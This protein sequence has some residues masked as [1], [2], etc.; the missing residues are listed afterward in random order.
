[1]VDLQRQIEYWINGAEDDII[2]AE[3]LFREKRNIHGL[4]FCHLVIEKAI[5]AH[6]VKNTGDVAPRT[7]NLIYLS[8]NAKLAFDDETQIFLGTLMKYQLE[9]RYPDCSPVLPDQKIVNEYFSK[10]K[11]VLQWL[12]MKL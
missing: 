1:M 12:K 2:T 10:T 11:E 8:E 6:F 7:H 9:G 4:F 3:L 5:K